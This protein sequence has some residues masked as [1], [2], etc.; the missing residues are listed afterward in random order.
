MI[1]IVIPCYNEEKRIPLEE[2]TAFTTK[3]PDVNLVFVNDGSTDGTLEMLKKWCSAYV[4]HTVVDLK[5]N[6]GKAEAVR[7]GMLVA[8]A[9]ENIRFVGFFDA[10]LATPLEEVFYLMQ[11]M[12]DKHVFAFGSRI[13]KVGSEISRK[14]YR[15]YLGRI[16]AT[17]ISIILRLDVYD[18]QCGAKLFR[19]EVVTTLFEKP[20]LSKW[21]F[22]VELFARM[23]RIYQN[24][25][26][27]HIIEVPLRT[28]IEKGD[29]K[30]TFLDT[31]KIP[32]EL[33]RIKRAY[34]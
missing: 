23:I 32:F 7:Q 17:F 24:K 31:L 30:I 25:T 29:S 26:S 34:K 14:A 10:D 2:F 5:Q 27:D 18:T 16:I 22:D 4:A 13:L 3:H 11:N 12:Q 8:E 21:L 28:W 33:L 15:H 9:Q 20:F 1:T 19:Q 6:S